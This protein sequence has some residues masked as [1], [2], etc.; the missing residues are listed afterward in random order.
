MKLWELSLYSALHGVHAKLH[1]I[2][3][4]KTEV[5]NELLLV[6]LDKGTT[7]I[8]HPENDREF[9]A[10]LIHELASLLPELVLANSRLR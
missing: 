6:A 1:V 3:P 9:T 7:N 4:L 8:F 2:P 10:E 5:A